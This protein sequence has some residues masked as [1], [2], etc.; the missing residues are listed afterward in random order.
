MDPR[1]AWFSPEQL[2][3]AQ[4]H[5]NELW[6]RSTVIVEDNMDIHGSA[7]NARRAHDSVLVDL[8]NSPN[9]A[10]RTPDVVSLDYDNNLVK[11]CGLSNKDHD[12]YNKQL[13]KRK[14][15]NLAITY[16][17]NYRQTRSNEDRDRYTPWRKRRIPYPAENAVVE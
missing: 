15:E 3:T 8:N 16:G 10:R 14:R 6:E 13:T 17:L 11:K 7:S 12:K 1:I 2:G 9:I 5:W 4:K